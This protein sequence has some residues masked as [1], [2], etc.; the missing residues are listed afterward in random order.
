[1]A[2]ISDVEMW[3]LCQELESLGGGI[4]T[5]LEPIHQLS[6]TKCDEHDPPF[7]KHLP[8]GSCTELTV[9][10]ISTFLKTACKFALQGF[11][12][13]LLT[14]GP[15]QS[16]KSTFLFTTS[17]WQVLL[18]EIHA[19]EYDAVYIEAFEYAQNEQASNL[20]GAAKK[21]TLLKLNPNLPVADQV[22]NLLSVMKQAS[23]NFDASLA[24]LKTSAH[25]FLKLHLHR[26]AS[27]RATL[28]ILD[29]SS[30]LATSLTYL[31][32]ILNSIHRKQA[33]ELKKSRLCKEFGRILQNA[34]ISVLNFS[35]KQPAFLKEI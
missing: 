33:T 27:E 25:L 30:Q 26:C 23:V 8:D 10:D 6:L 20:L 28:S 29:C 34:Q 31:G 35:D 32:Y 2:Q 3:Q 17:F 11:S 14:S 1:M 9:H 22:Q 4:T 21:P 5:R 12:S 15:T 13:T 19:H 16:G 18:S 7:L 24:P